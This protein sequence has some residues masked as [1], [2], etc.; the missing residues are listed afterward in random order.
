[1]HPFIILI[2]LLGVLYGVHWYKSASGK[3]QKELRKKTLIGGAIAI[4][5]LLLITG[6][7]S[8]LFAALAA[9]VPIGFRV[10]GLLQSARNLEGPFSIFSALGRTGAQGPRPGVSTEWLSLQL[11]HATGGIDGT[12]LK[13]SFEGRRLSTLS[14][15]E[16]LALH[17]QCRHEPRSCA[18]LEAYL[19]RV[20]GNGWRD[21]VAGAPAVAAAAP[22]RP[23]R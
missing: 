19:D 1:M 4:V 9:A 18:S 2:I 10:L 3:K 20:H 11:D 8:P 12:V 17:G 6:R 13:G 23:G 21:T 22:W 16:L 5:V 15:R 7:L 14:L